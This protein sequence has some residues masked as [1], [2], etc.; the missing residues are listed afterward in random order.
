MGGALYPPETTRSVTTPA[1]VRT[2]IDS[3]GISG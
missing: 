2:I 3:A 1:R